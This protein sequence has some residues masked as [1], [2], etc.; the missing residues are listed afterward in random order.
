MPTV[1]KQS[2]RDSD[3]IRQ[4]L[5]AFYGAVGSW[6]KVAAENP[7]YPVPAGTLCT[8]AKNGYLPVKWYHHFRLQELKPAPACSDCGE[9]HVKNRCPEKPRRYRD[10]WAVP[11]EILREWLENREEIKL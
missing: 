10:L 2:V 5:I 3:T 8:W 1:K 4:R 6:R 9:V 11:P 7:W